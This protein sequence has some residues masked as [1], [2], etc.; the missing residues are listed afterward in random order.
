[1]TTFGGAFGAFLLRQFFLTIPADLLDATRVD[2]A[3]HLRIFLSIVLPLSKPG[4]A[5]LAVLVFVS[6]W[7]AF[8]GP[9]IYARR[10][11][12]FTLTVGLS[13]LVRGANQA[14]FWNQVMAGSV[15]SVLPMVLIFLLAQKYF[16]RGIVLSG[17]KG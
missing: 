1:L 13:F 10:E 17:M 11:D 16:V 8:L 14:T 3:G 9:L 5:T 2:G 15:I 12:L 4:L 6:A 7:N